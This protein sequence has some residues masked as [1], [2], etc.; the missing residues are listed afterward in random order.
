MRQDRR[1][2]GEL[3][4]LPVMNLLTIL[5]P[6]L[7]LGAQLANLGL[8]DSTLPAISPDDSAVPPPEPPLSLT[9]AITKAGFTVL[10]ADAILRGAAD[11]V[12]VPCVR[13]TCRGPDDYD[14]A[15]LTRLMA[16]VKDAFPDHDNV[17][18]TPDGSVPYQVL[19]GTMDATRISGERPLFPLVA[20][21]GGAAG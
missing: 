20:I 14:Y 1:R 2:K 3:N 9:V 7:L 8:I 19:I 18:L 21:A 6:M 13:T 16:L 11:D 12:T 15:E 4:L 10:G 17:V 5:I